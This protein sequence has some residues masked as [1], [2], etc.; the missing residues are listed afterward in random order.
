MAWA[1][2][3]HNIGDAPAQRVTLRD[4]LDREVDLNS[5]LLDVRTAP[6]IPYAI[7]GQSLVFRAGEVAPGGSGRIAVSWPP[8]S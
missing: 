7:D 2:E 1:I 3:Y 5:V 4:F 8:A 6:E